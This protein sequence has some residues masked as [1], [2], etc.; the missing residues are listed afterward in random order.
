MAASDCLAATCPLRGLL[1]SDFFL[2]AI[3][4]TPLSAGLADMALLDAILL[5]T[6]TSTSALD[7]SLAYSSATA[8][9]RVAS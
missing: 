7:L 4:T 8:C 5:H 2:A 1:R 9:R 3:G 6:A